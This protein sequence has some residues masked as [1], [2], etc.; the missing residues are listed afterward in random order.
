M[1]LKVLIISIIFVGLAFAGFAIKI[2]SSKTGEFKKSCDEVDIDN[3]GNVIARKGKGKKKIMAGILAGLG[4][5]I[6]AQGLSC[7]ALIIVIES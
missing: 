2:I 7:L 5:G 4:I 6:V 1:L 3:F